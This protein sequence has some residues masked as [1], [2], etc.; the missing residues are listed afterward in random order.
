MAAVA[1]VFSE[2]IEAF[3]EF[4]DNPGGVALG[5]EYEHID[6]VGAVSEQ[7]RTLAEHLRLNSP[8]SS[9]FTTSNDFPR[10]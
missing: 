1:L 8:R 7:H 9:D 3:F 5:E 6:G 10:L 4:S 2:V